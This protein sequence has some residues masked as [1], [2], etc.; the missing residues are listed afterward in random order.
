MLKNGLLGRHRYGI[1][2]LRGIQSSTK[3]LQKKTTCQTVSYS[4]QQILHTRL[5]GLRSRLTLVK[6]TTVV[7]CSALAPSVMVNSCTGKMGCAAAEAIF[8]AGLELIPLTVTGETKQQIGK[9]T[10][11]K[12]GGD[13]TKKK[14]EFVPLED[15]D[16]CLKEV[17]AQYKN[18]IVV[19]F[20]LPQCVNENG[21]LYSE[22]GLNFVM[23]TTG[24]DRQKLIEEVEDTDV[25]A[26]IAPQMG[27]QVVAFQAMLKYMSERFPGAFTGYTLTVT[28]S[29]QASKVDTSGT[30]RAII[31]SFEALGAPLKSEISMVRDPKMS[32]KMGVPEEALSGHAYHTY[33]LSSPDESVNFEF[34]HNVAGRA[35][36]AEGTVDAVLFLSQKIK[37]KCSKKVFNMIDVLEAGSMR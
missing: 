9:N 36:Y 8:G 19:D 21:A 14:I 25:Y 23:G 1:Y 30:A 27:K 3:L 15:R 37:E 11:M 5:H 6:P 28:E 2:R 29:H 13:K 20:T 26:V 10:S 22:L 31:D 34:Q 17:K 7:K 35:I 16:D 4:C 32:L 12:L 33:H 24:G 18:L